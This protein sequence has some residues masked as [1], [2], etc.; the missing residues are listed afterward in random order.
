MDLPSR[1]N[2]TLDIDDF[3]T[4]GLFKEDVDSETKFVL[5]VSDRDSNKGLF[6]WLGKIAASMF[7]TVIGGRV[8]QITN[9]F[10]G[11]VASELQGRLDA[12]L[13]DAKSDDPKVQ[14]L[15][16][17]IEIII[18]LTPNGFDAYYKSGRRRV[19]VTTQNRIEIDLYASKSFGVRRSPTAAERRRSATARG[20]M[21]IKFRKGSKIGKAVVLVS[22]A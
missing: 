7:S 19:S 10:Q 15:G 5:L 18:E 11:A 21:D 8:K 4:S 16:K 3:W 9:L 22:G 17:S 12:G 6:S 13:K 1:T 14:S 20:R 2:V